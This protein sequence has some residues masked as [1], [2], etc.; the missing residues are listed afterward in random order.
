[1]LAVV[2]WIVKQLVFILV[3][4]VLQHLHTVVQGLGGGGMLLVFLC[5]L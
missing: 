2:V 5:D 3:G 4:L 1:M